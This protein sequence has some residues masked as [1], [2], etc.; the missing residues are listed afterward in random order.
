MT[1]GL[2]GYVDDAGIERVLRSGAT[3]QEIPK[4]LFDL[5]LEQGSDD[6]ITVQYLQFGEQSGAQS[7]LKRF[8]SKFG[9]GTFEEPDQRNI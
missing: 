3:V 5:A 1:D 7:P 6:N 2:S 9:H 4:R 8:F